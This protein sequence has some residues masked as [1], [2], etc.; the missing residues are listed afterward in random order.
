MFHFDTD[1]MEHEGMTPLERAAH[2]TMRLVR[3]EELTARAIARQYGVS[4]KTAYELLGRTSRVVPIYSE[5]GVW[6]LMDVCPLE[7]VIPASTLAVQ[8]S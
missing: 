2:V 7:P 5:H 8:L 1:A 4:R 6:R 3:G